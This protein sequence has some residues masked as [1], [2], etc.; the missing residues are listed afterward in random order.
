MAA[1]AE[2]SDL[3]A[4]EMA[5]MSVD[6]KNVSRN[7]D[8]AGLAAAE[9]LIRAEAAASPLDD[10]GCDG[11][12]LDLFAEPEETLVETVGDLRFE[13][14]G[15]ARD[16]GQTLACTGETVWRGCDL[17][18]AW[19]TATDRRVAA[20]VELGCGLGLASLVALHAGVAARAVATDGDGKALDKCARNAAAN[21]TADGRTVAVA[22]LRWGD[23]DAVDALRAEANGG[24]AFDLVL[25]A[26]VVYV[27]GAVAP[28]ARTAARLLSDAGVFVLAFAR[29][30]VDVETFLEAAAAAGLESADAA[31]PEP[32]GPHERLLVLRKR[33]T[34]R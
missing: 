30:G 19:L 23:D 18:G 21:A 4:K 29:R 6:H 31:S 33:V 20:S 9:A 8:A 15:F 10:D 2:A 12:G 14:V 3:I 25:G 7:F 27:D 13:L 34:T 5:A 32:L 1:L 28:L 26:D 22:P 11:G 16:S 24:A 17:L